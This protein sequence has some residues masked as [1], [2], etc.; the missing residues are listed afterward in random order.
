[1]PKFFGK[2]ADTYDKV[3]RWATFG[4]DNYWKKEILRQIPKSDSI[5]DLACGTGI[6][7]RKIAKQF[8]LA[9]ITGVDI[10]E[11]YLAVAKK[12]SQSY[13]NV[14]FLKQDAEDLR[15]Q[16]KFDCIVSSYIP[17]YC[18]AETLVQKCLEHLNP[19][20]KIVLHDFV[21]PKNKLVRKF[22]MVHF[23]FLRFVGLFVTNWRDAFS[24]LPYLIENNAWIDDYE[25]A[26]KRHGFATTKQ[27]LTL[28]TSA[29]LLAT[30]TPVQ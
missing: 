28:N 8:P 7:T 24:I 4:K 25:N 29:I 15:L 2:T 12:N 26:M 14:I 21:Y 18:N 3:A 9:K 6:L 13:K 11:N 27:Y 16:D 23:V 1:M 20:G 30:N 5:L 17:K 19:G 22:W 10:S